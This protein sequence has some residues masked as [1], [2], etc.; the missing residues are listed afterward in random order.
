MIRK[1]VAPTVS[2]TPLAP[3]VDV[4]FL[5]LVFFIFSYQVRVLEQYYWVKVPP[6]A[7]GTARETR[8]ATVRLEATAAGD[9]AA[10]TADGRR[11][12]TLDEFASEIPSRLPPPNAAPTILVEPAGALHYEHV[13]D[14]SMAIRQNGWQPGLLR[15]SRQEGE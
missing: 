3:L 8:L 6:S 14:V 1:R 15:A 2:E 13:V 9:L 10:I 11:W 7:A 4:V 12:A 5:L